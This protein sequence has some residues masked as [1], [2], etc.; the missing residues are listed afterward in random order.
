MKYLKIFILPFIMFLFFNSAC[1]FKSI[2]GSGNIIKNS[3]SVSGFN[4]VEISGSGHLF[5][6]QGNTE[7]LQ[8]EC[9]DNIEPHILSTVT[10]KTLDIGP[11]NV[12]LNPS[13]AIKYTLSLKNL[14][15]LKTSG[16]IKISSNL[17]RTENLNVVMNGSGKFI[18]GRIEAQSVEVDINGSCKF[19]IESGNVKHQRLSISGSGKFNVSN[20]KS[21]S[22]DVKISGSGKT[23]LWLADKLNIK[24]SGSGKLH[25]YGSPKI[26]SNVSGSGKI[27]SLGEK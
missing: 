15:A 25:Y 10:N 1:D 16:A 12:N 21:E 24:I 17:L 27:D 9:D 5:I 2:N 6:I 11:N 18:L 7:S 14:H 8:I 13:E 19:D 23:T 22:A 20:L 3:R 4:R 26:S